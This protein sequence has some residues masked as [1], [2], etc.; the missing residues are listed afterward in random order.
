MEAARRPFGYD[1]ISLVSER[2][3]TRT[4]MIYSW[5]YPES[6][7]RSVMIEVNPPCHFLW[8]PR[9]TDEQVSRYA[10]LCSHA[11]PPQ[12][13]ARSESGSAARRR[14]SFTSLR[15][16]SDSSIPKLASR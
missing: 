2:A 11:A 4:A 1:R 12:P 8:D 15:V 5:R 13:S 14:A 3:G 10:E 9:T 7:H 16:G 6:I